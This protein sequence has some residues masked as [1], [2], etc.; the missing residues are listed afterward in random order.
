MDV[1]RLVNTCHHCIQESTRL[2]K[3]KQ[4][5]TLFPASEPLE[6]VAIDLLGPL[7]K[8]P[9]GNQ[10]LMVMCD[11]FSKLVRTVPLR[12]I[13][14][15]AVAQAF[16]SRWVFVYGMPQ[17]LL[18]DNGGQFNSKFFQACCIEL[19]IKQ[20]FATAYHP[21][22]NGQ[23]ERFNRT[24]LSQLR[25]YVGEHQNDWDLYHGALTFAYNNQIHTS[26]NVTPFEL[27]LSRP[28][29]HIAIQ[30][31]DADTKTRN[32]SLLDRGVQGRREH[33]ISRI[34]D[35]LPR[36]RKSI[37]RA[38]HRYCSKVDLIA[39]TEV[40][41]LLPLCPRVLYIILSQ[42]PLWWPRG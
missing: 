31:F 2:K 10:F 17:K 27:V 34:R 33:F 8:S 36:V 26:T 13:N 1:T 3:R 16:C 20:V 15:L 7:P 22:F 18:S 39:V 35:L 6:F 12:S 9:R 23:V 32:A 5:V 40:S 19:G 30:I 21:Q 24:I 41:V 29:P 4:G 28:P 11:R 37:E 14:S 25:A 42:C 38:G